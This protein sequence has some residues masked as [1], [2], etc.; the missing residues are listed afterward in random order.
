MMSVYEIL[1]CELGRQSYETKEEVSFTSS[2]FKLVQ[3]LINI[4]F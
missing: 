2:L 1:N 4:I 3:I